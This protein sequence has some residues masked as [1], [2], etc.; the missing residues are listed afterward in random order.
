MQSIKLKRSF[1]MVM[2]CAQPIIFSRI[3]DFNLNAIFSHQISICSQKYC[4]DLHFFMIKNLMMPQ[5]NLQFPFEIHTIQERISIVNR[6]TQF[7]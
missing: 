1:E 7:L 2:N 4:V 6:T 5:T 3:R